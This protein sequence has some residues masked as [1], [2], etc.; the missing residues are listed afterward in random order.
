MILLIFIPTNED[1]YLYKVW[2]KYFQPDERYGPDT[3]PYTKLTRKVI[4]LKIGTRD[5][6]LVFCSSSDVVPS[7]YQVS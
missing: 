2:L 1:A 5:T 3:I 4:P 7:L 6:V